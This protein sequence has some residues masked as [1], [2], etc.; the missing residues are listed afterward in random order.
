MAVKNV[1]DHTFIDQFLRMSDTAEEVHHMPRHKCYAM[2]LTCLHHRFAVCIGQC[3][4]L[5]T[6]YMHAVL[7]SLDHRLL[8]QIIRRS[9]DHCVHI[10]TAKQRIKVCLY[11]TS[12]FLCDHL[13]ILWIIHCRDSSS[14]LFLHDPSKLCPKITRTDYCIT[15]IFHFKISSN[16]IF[17]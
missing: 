16:Y 8:M 3:D 10:F 15:Y 9:D 2:L 17:Y 4:G 7:C 1:S 14:F 13:C 12:Q 11:F 5:L 6:E